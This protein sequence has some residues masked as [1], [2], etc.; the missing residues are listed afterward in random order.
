MSMCLSNM[1]KGWNVQGAMLSCCLD[2]VAYHVCLPAAQPVTPLHD[3][4]AHG[5]TPQTSSAATGQACCA[6]QNAQQ[7][8]ARAGN[9][10]RLICTWLNAELDLKSVACMLAQNAVR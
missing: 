9:A 5:T 8:L 10:K 6:T 2:P 1:R 3:F 4:S 7:L